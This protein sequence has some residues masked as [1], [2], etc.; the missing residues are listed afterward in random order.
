MYFALAYAISW[1]LFV[2]SRLA[3]G[4]LGTVLIVIGA[5]G[6][7]I[8]AAITIRYSGGSLTDWLRAIIRWRVPVGFYLYALG[9][10]VLIMATM[11]AVLAVL[12]Q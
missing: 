2:L 8:A 4:T 3:G 9:L 6:P 7:P 12:G 11:N 10:P 1:P 5:F